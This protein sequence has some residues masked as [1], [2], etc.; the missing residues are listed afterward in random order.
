M[1]CPSC[2]RNIEGKWSLINSSEKRPIECSDCGEKLFLDSVFFLLAEGGAL[3]IV[4]V[5]LILLFINWKYSLL[6]LIV[7]VV[8]TWAAIKLDIKYSKLIVANEENVSY[9]KLKDFLLVIGGGLVVLLLLF[10]SF[11][12][13]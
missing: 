9:F 3:A 12:L 4:P 13:I 8:M 7:L 1:K 11:K 6:L 2:N 5:T 10:A